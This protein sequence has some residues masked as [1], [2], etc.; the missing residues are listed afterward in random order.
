MALFF[1]IMAECSADHCR[2]FAEVA[3][4]IVPMGFRCWVASNRQTNEYG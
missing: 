4:M 1:A 3:R 2:P